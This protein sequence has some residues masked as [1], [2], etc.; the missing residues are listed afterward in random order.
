MAQR[1]GESGG[2]V[3]ADLDAIRARMAQTRADMG[4]KLGKLKSRLLDPPPRKG[5]KDTMTQKK[6]ATAGKKKTAAAAKKTMKKAVSKTKKVL[7]E[8]MAGAAV[9][10]VKGAAE[11]VMPDEK[12][13]A[14]GPKSEK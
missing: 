4:R 14:K 1:T 5:K 3:T 10:A 13:S 11:A 6:K 9:G 8:M 12:S 2:D 7:G